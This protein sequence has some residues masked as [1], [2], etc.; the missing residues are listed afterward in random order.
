D[1][2]KGERVLVLEKSPG[3]VSLSPDER[4]LVWYD[5]GER[6]YLAMDVRNRRVRNPTEQVPSPVHDEL[7]DQPMP[8][9]PYGA[10]G[11]TDAGTFLVYDRY[12]IWELDPTGRRAPRNVTEGVG[13]AEGLRFRYAQLDPDAEVVATAEPILLHAFHRW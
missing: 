9:P 5:G 4:H 8:P 11:W 7:N 6:A 12:D 2:E 1:V 10:A 3:P 13:R